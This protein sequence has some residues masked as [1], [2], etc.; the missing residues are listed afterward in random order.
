VLSGDVHHAYVAEAQFDADL[1]SRVYQLTCS[2]LHNYVPRVMKAGFRM[3]WS[4]V[5]ELATRGL[6]GVTA[7]LPELPMS[8]K[9]EAGPFF[10]NELMVFDADGRRS[11]ITL[12]KTR[13]GEKTPQLHEAHQVRLS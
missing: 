1:K 12:H 8:W 4:R 5:A 9:R 3:S 13:A 7:R 10:G 6:L 11:T 2:P